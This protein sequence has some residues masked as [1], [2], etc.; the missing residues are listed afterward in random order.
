MGGYASAVSEQQ[1]GKYVPTTT[2]TN[3]T[4]EELCFLCGPFR[5]VINK[6]QDPF[7]QSVRDTASRR[8]RRKG[9]SEI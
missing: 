2:D 1:L 4:V 7:S 8:R 5:G 3:A 6:R 9:K